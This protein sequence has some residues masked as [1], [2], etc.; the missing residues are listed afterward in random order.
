MSISVA[1]ALFLASGLVVFGGALVAFGVALYLGYT[2]GDVLS[3]HFQNSSFLL[4]LGIKR[5]SSFYGRIQL[6]GNISS[7][8][9][10]PGFFLNEVW[11]ALRT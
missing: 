4:T 11:P 7:I 8:L 2:K 6:I 1:D 9:T 5:R 3:E 10:F